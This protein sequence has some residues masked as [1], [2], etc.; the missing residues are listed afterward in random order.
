MTW[1]HK[2]AEEKPYI[3]LICNPYEDA[4]STNTR[5]TIEIME[6]DLGRTEMIEVF[7]KFMIAM[8]YHFNESEHLGIEHF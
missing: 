1:N 7:E 5:I 8:G 2:P 4:S 3:T 6:K